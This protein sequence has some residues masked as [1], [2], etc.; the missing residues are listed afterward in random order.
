MSSESTMRRTG[1]YRHVVFADAIDGAGRAVNLA[2]VDGHDIEQA[3]DAKQAEFLEWLFGKANIDARQYRAEAMARRLP[4]CMRALRVSNVEGARLAIARDPAL[5]N[6]ALNA[7]LIG[8]T[9]FFRDKAAFDA[10]AER[11]LPELLGRTG[12]ELRVWSV[13]CSN[14]AELYSVA[15]LLNELGVTEGI[16][17]LGTDC[18]MDATRAAAAGV[19]DSHR[20]TGIS[21]ERLLRHFELVEPSANAGAKA[22]EPLWK[23]KEALRRVPHW[24]TADLLGTVEPGPWDLILCRN[25]AMYLRPGAA[26]DL[27]GRLSNVM[28]R[29]GYLVLGKAERPSGVGQ[30]V[31]AGQYLYR[32]VD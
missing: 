25:A 12:G 24:R 20:L 2:P 15:M 14:G 8:V 31:S 27:W 32:R 30:L 16:E 10:L 11:V 23:V 13:G 6:D 29:A 5:V 3:L 4:A 1:R 9:E 28:T 17:L 22:D 7:M 19:Y 18:R 26:A 21:G